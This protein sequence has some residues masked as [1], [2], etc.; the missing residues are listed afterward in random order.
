MIYAN[1]GNVRSMDIIRTA[2]MLYAIKLLHNID[3]FVSTMRGAATSGHALRSSDDQR[4]KSVIKLS[5]VDF[6]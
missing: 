2:L 4:P 5:D 1:T 3:G 6:S